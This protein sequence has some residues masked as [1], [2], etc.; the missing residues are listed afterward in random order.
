MVGDVH[1][2][3]LDLVIIVAEENFHVSPCTCRTLARGCWRTMRGRWESMEG[4]ESRRL[5]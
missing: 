3:G 5:R 2:P 4:P 1:E